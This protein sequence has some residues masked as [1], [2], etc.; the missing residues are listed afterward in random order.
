M[1]SVTA[2]LLSVSVAA[3]LCGA[4]LT[5]ISDDMPRSA[6]RQLAISNVTADRDLLSGDGPSDGRD[7]GL[8][9]VPGDGSATRALLPDF[10]PPKDLAGWASLQEMHSV[11]TQAFVESEGFGMQRRLT[12]DSPERRLLFVDG[13]PYRMDSMKLLSLMQGDP[14]AYDST[15]VNMTREGLR[16]EQQR[17]LTE[18]E[19]A[20][21]RVLKTGQPYV[22]SESSHATDRK[23]EVSDSVLGNGLP[24]QMASLSRPGRRTVLAE[25]RAGQSCVACHEVAEGTLLGAFIYE[26]SEV[27]EQVALVRSLSRPPTDR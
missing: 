3:A 5:E 18:F 21:L 17:P 16:V 27:G 1:T 14:V 13:Q 2:R 10:S 8:G 4:V 20:S 19:T 25:L 26:F 7:T 23:T 11:Y 9:A 12:F 22:V 6:D 15:W 24:P